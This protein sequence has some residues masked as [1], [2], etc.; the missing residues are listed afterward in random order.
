MYVRAE[1]R[2][3]GVGAALVAAIIEH[4]P[5]GVDQITLTVVAE[6]GAAV[7]LYTRFGFTVYGVEPNALKT[8]AGYSSEVLMVKFL[9]PVV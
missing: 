6:N 5:A 4:A 9:R 7:A 1:E 8:K 2:R 3:H